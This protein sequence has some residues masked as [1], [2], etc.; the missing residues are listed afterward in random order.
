[1]KSKK[2]SE[3]MLK[4]TL[5]L[6]VESNIENRSILAISKRILSKLNSMRSKENMMMI[7]FLKEK[8]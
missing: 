1:M 2:S 3:K 8:D 7:L 4:L 5:L 6:N